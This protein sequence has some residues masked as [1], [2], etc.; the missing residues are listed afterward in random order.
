MYKI[1]YVVTVGNAIELLAKRVLSCCLVIQ[2]TSELFGSA[3]FSEF[4]GTTR[5]VVC[6]RTVEY[7]QW[8]SLAGRMQI[9]PVVS[10]L[11]ECFIYREI[12]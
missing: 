8:K 12:E 3:D 11:S 10:P 1:F 7:R 6:R 4:K 9:G 2:Y 5:T